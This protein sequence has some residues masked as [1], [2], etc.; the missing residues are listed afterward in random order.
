MVR[1]RLFFFFFFETFS[2]TF[3]DQN[4][5]K[6]KLIF[7][8]NFLSSLS[9][10]L[11]LSLS[12]TVTTHEEVQFYLGLLNQQLPIESQL[13]GPRLVDTLNAEIQLGTVT[14]MREATTWLSYT[15]LYVRTLRAPKVYKVGVGQELFDPTADPTLLKHRTE[16]IHTACMKLARCSLIRY[17]SLS[18]SLIFDSYKNCYDLS[19]PLSLDTRPE[20]DDK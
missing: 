4:I 15:Y 2:E 18:V 5:R 11:S 10:S 17:V 12:H 13:G 14:S 7:F 16:M 19:R 20:D 3:S 8:S 9:L 6:T 1:R